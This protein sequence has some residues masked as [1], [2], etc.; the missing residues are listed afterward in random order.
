MYNFDETVFIMSVNYLKLQWLSQAR[1]DTVVMQNQSSLGGVTGNNILITVIQAAVPSF[2]MASAMIASLLSNT[3]TAHSR[4]LNR[5]DIGKRLDY[6]E[7]GLEW[8]QHFEKHA[9]GR[10]TGFHRLPVLD[11][12]EQPPN[13]IILFL[14]LHAS[15]LVS[16]PLTIRCWEF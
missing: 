4:R 9:K 12:Q 5:R 3:R 13:N 11:G 7:R 8:I 14:A 6:Q 15:R 1:K 10:T 16:H 2:I